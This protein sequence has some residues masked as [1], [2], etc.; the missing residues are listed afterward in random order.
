[1]K[2]G[3]FN[4]HREYLIW[5][6]IQAGMKELNEIEPTFKAVP[7]SA[8]LG[9]N[10]ILKISFDLKGDPTQQWQWRTTYVPVKM[11]EEGG[12]FFVTCLVYG[13]CVARLQKTR[14]YAGIWNTVETVGSERFNLDAEHYPQDVGIKAAVQMY[15]TV[16]QARHLR[17]YESV[18]HYGLGND[19]TSIPAAFSLTRTINAQHGVRINLAKGEL[20][21]SPSGF[22]NY[23][24][25]DLPM[26]CMV[27]IP[28]ALYDKTP[29][30]SFISMGVF[31][32]EVF[33]FVQKKKK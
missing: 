21:E 25:M 5:K 17:N 27:F 14:A 13:A 29:S 23:D 24:K 30:V 6:K 31:Y 1:M 15:E 28:K 7:R 9:D 18:G 16:Q 32:G 11:V 20:H 12:S 19:V 2:A 33:S 4:N 3:T 26:R 22:V 10:D 8:M